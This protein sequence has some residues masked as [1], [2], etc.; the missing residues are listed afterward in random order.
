M[1]TTIVALMMILYVVGR[2]WLSFVSH[3]ANELRASYNLTVE[4][5]DNAIMVALLKAF[6]TKDVMRIHIEL[7]FNWMAKFA[8]IYLFT[9]FRWSGIVAVA[10]PN[11]CYG[12][13]QSAYMVGGICCASAS[14]S[15]QTWCHN[16]VSRISWVI[17]DAGR[18]GRG[19]PWC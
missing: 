12:T 9:I 14:R 8:F 7:K 4:H 17:S 3:T 15:G 5:C 2:S 11:K 16:Q 1:L 19:S 10:S 18:T 13:R 6:L